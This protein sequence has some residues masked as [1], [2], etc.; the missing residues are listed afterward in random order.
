MAKKTKKSI[1]VEVNVVTV[2][3]EGKTIQC[4]GVDV[5]V[6]VN[7]SGPTLTSKSSGALHTAIMSAIQTTA[8]A[9][10]VEA[11]ISK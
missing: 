2:T 6:W 4:D 8:I 1:K 7:L 3:S 10:A 9:S 11:A 5:R